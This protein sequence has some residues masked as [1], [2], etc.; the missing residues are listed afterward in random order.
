MTLIDLGTA[1]Y[2]IEWLENM[3]AKHSWPDTIKTDTEERTTLGISLAGDGITI[4]EFDS[5][6]SSS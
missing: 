1:A 5:R 6:A 3:P 2:T 4:R